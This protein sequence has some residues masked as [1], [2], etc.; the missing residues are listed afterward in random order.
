MVEFPAGR[1]VR[2]F[3]NQCFLFLEK[4]HVLFNKMLD[5]HFFYF[6]WCHASSVL[7]C[8]IISYLGLHVYLHLL[9]VMCRIHGLLACRTLFTI[10]ALCWLCF[11]I[12]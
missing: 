3:L 10:G 1:K 12:R 7:L 5:G 6:P 9:T 2:T 11:M 8:F 4:G